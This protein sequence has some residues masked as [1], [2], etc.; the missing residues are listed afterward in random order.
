MRFA[1][2]DKGTTLGVIML[3]VPQ[4]FKGSPALNDE[5][6]VLFQ[7]IDLYFCYSFVVLLSPAL[8]K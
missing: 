6:S 4:F 1:D 8:S 2:G 7:S 5:S 3:G